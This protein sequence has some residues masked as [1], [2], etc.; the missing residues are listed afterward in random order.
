MSSPRPVAAA[1]VGDPR[2][3]ARDD[4]AEVPASRSTRQSCMSA[5]R[6][7][8]RSPG[9]LESGAEPERRELEVDG[10]LGPNPRPHRK[11]GCSRCSATARVDARPVLA[12]AALWRGW[13]AKNQLVLRGGSCSTSPG[14]DRAK[15][16]E[17][18]T[19]A[20]RKRSGAAWRSKGLGR[21]RAER[22]DVEAGSTTRNVDGG[23]RHGRSRPGGASR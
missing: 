13:R 8:M 19:A 12:L 23:R 10:N 21:H 22:L 16:L 4:D 11:V 2:R 5:T 18:R 3:P 6:R 15:G 1:P 20:T 7:L 17:K 9:A 14:H